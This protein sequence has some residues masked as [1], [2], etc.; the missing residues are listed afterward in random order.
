MNFCE[1]IENICKRY[2]KVGTFCGY[3]WNNNG[4]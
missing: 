1:K 3:G 2:K 4:I